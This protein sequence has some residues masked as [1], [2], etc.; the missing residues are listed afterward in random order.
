M[1]FQCRKYV[2]TLNLNPRDVIQIE[3]AKKIV[4][5]PTDG[6]GSGG[7]AMYSGLDPQHCCYSTIQKHTVLALLLFSVQGRNLF[8]LSSSSRFVYSSQVFST[9]NH[10]HQQLV[11]DLYNVKMFI[12]PIQYLPIFLEKNIKRVHLYFQPLCM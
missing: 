4:N 7:A 12:L 3:R 5:L 8:T 6:V 1:S 10:F 11:K 9:C 2:R